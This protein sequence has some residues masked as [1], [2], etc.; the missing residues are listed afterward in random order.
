MDIQY[1]CYRAQKFTLFR[2]QVAALALLATLGGC[3]ASGPQPVVVRDP[4]VTGCP[5][6]SVRTCEVIGGNK[7]QKRYGRCICAAL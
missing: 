6:G 1:R 2:K 7:F 5:V 3:A 4:L